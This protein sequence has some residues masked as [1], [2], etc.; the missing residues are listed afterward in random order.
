MA[1]SDIADM[2]SPGGTAL[3][4]DRQVARIGFGAMRLADHHGRSYDKQTGI[5]ILRRAVERGVNHIDTAQFYGAGTVNEMIRA[6]LSPYRENVVLATKVGA[7]YDEAA[8]LLPAQQ[9]SQLREQVEANLAALGVDT[10]GV[11]NI[12][13]LDGPPGIIAGPDQIV[14]LDDQ[15]AELIA[16]RDEGK[17]TGIGLSNVDAERLTHAL[18]A[19]IVCVQNLYNLLNRTEEPVLTVCRA[20]NIAWVPYFPLGGGTLATG[21]SVT[22]H[23][24]VL[25]AAKTLDVTPSQIGLAWLLANYSGTL[26]I[27]GTSSPDHLDEN[28]AAG[29]ID[30]PPDVLD[31]LNGLVEAVD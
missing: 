24:A 19:G 2:P 30:I 4:G 8:R 28:L 17:I 13:R 11:V 18:P 21:P 1:A 31:V 12:R 15:L 16:L 7:V 29:S 25:D 9:P 5:D 10:L 20:N 22:D 23:P 26:L 14:D 27:P 6:A 3:L